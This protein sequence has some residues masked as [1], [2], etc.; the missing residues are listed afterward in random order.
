MR[1]SCGFSLVELLVVIS[2]VALLMALLLPALSAA[3]ARAQQVQCLAQQRQLMQ[4]IVG[5]S[6][7]WRDTLPPHILAV[8]PSAP[9]NPSRHETWLKRLVTEGFLRELPLSGS[10]LA[11]GRGDVRLCPSMTLDPRLDYNT[12]AQSFGHYMMAQEVCGYWN[13]E[14]WFWERTPLRLSTVIKP[15]HTMATSDAYME[16]DTGVIRSTISLHENTNPVYR[17][18]PGMTYVSHVRDSRWRHVGD[19]SAFTF[20]DGH[21]EIRTWDKADPWSIAYLPWYQGG[22]GRLIGPLRGKRYDG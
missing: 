10:R 15:A 6:Q 17:C 18:R 12:A 3:R 21:G 20:L 11:G 22:F 8:V 19:S 16:V 13:G 4:M 1:L 7:E 2:V 9:G 14:E 5:Y